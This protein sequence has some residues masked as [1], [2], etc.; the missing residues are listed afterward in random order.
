MAGLQFIPG[1]L[2]PD[3]TQNLFLFLSAGAFLLCLAAFVVERLRRGE[4]RRP[5]APAVALLATLLLTGAGANQAYQAMPAISAN[6]RDLADRIALQNFQMEKPA[7]GFWLPDGKGGVVRTAAYPGRILFIYLFA[8]DDL[9]AA[10]TLPAL[11]Q[12]AGELGSR[13]VQPIGVCLSPDRGDGWALARTGG[14]RF[15]IGSDP[16]T[17]KSASPPEAAVTTAYNASILPLLIVTD[18]RRRV[19]E[20]RNDLPMDAIALRQIALRR[21]REEPE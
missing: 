9:D 20:Q 21:L 2:R 3:F 5:L 11:D 1:Y 13:G 12:L 19:R 4:L 15:P 17:L 8:A 7:P 10:R 16:S 14:Y 18:R 6:G